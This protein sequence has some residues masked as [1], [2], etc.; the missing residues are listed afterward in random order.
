LDN[1]VM[2]ASIRVSSEW[3]CRH[4]AEQQ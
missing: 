2:L 1:R 3:Q 4:A